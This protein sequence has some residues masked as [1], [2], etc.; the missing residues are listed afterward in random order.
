MKERLGFI[1]MGIMGKPMCINLLKAG[2][3]VTAYNRTASKMEDVIKAGAVPADSPK[4]VAEASDLIITIVTDSPDVKEIV[5]GKSGII[6]GIQKNSVLI[7]MST[8]SPTVTRKIAADL[9]KKDAHML[10][11][12]VSGGDSGAITGTLAIMVGGDKNVFQRCLPV[13]NVLGKSVTHVGEHGMGQI[14]KL[15]NQILVSV[16]NMAV[17]ESILFAQK[18]G[19]DPETMIRATSQGAGGSWQLSNLGPKIIKQDFSPG[20]TIELQLKDLRLALESTGKTE[21]PLPALTLVNELFLLNKNNHEENE[22]TQALIKA[23][24]RLSK[25]SP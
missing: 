7:D 21:Q 12:P 3:K 22:G 20:F 17:C 9:Q 24:S 19:L 11:A 4:A 25:S 15:C 18:N 10:D 23:I 6:H 5:L 16:T 14:A 8:I 2:Y 1:G 13:L